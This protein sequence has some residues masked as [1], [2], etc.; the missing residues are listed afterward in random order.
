MEEEWKDVVG[1]E[2][3]YQVNKFGAVR[4][5]DK[6]RTITYTTG[7]IATMNFSGKVLSPKTEKSGYITQSITNSGVRK[8]I[9][10]HRMVAM[11]FIPNPENKPQVNHK[12]GIKSDNRVE[13][14]EWVTTFENR[15]HAYDTGLQK[16]TSGTIN[17]MCTHSDRE[18]EFIKIQYALG[19]RQIDIANN[20]GFSPSMVN[21]IV[22][23]KAW[24]HIRNFY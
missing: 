5:L 14:L 9:K 6:L 12:N 13:N 2:G 11:A 23:N 19:M 3:L 8:T 22:K 4:S 15:Q 20:Y 24:K 10:V 1:Y 17:G 18:I 7:T 21:L 16:P